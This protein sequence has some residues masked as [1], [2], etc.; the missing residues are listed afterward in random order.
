MFHCF[1]ID[2]FNGLLYFLKYHAKLG[3]KDELAYFVFE[4]VA[5]D[6]EQFIDA[7]EKVFIATTAFEQ[8]DDTF[9]SFLSLYFS[10]DNS[11]DDAC[12]GIPMKTSKKI[13]TKALKNRIQMRILKKNS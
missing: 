13:L 10:A 9:R 8:L 7:F 1:Y 3:G 4:I 5:T 2:E 11:T 6:S 12:Q